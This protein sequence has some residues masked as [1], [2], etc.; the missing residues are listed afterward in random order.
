MLDKKKKVRGILCTLTGGICWGFS[1]TCGQYLFMNKGIE[2]AWLTMIR[3]VFAG[4]ILLIFSFFT[5]RNYMFQIWTIKKDILRLLIFGFCGILV[6]QFTYLTAIYYSNAGTATVLQYTSPVLIMIVV[7]CM[8]KRF[9]DRIEIF[10]I[11]L[12]LAGTFLLATHGSVHR[13]S[14]SSQGLFWG[15]AS[16]IGAVFYSVTPGRLVEKWSSPVVTGYAMLIAGIFFGLFSGKWN[17]QVSMDFSATLAISAIVLIGTALAYTL[18][19][20]GVSDIGP[21]KS[22]MLASVEPVAAALFSMLWLKTSFMWIDLI[23]FA[24]ILTTVF[25]LSKIK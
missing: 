13:L 22:S 5:N 19:I 20:Q 18:F 15:L 25:L 10:S 9:P 8:S 11:I 14:I 1:G 3:M 17:R 16:S 21:V 4:L 12:A 2:S 24:C 7:C 23:G 6:S